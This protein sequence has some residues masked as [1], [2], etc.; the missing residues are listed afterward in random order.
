MKK[1]I[2][3]LGA[4]QFDL[5]AILANMGYSI[6][7]GS[8]HADRENI[9]YALEIDAA[10]LSAP[11]AVIAEALDAVSVGLHGLTGNDAREL[12]AERRIMLE[13]YATRFHEAAEMVAVNLISKHHPEHDQNL[14]VLFSKGKGEE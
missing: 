4:D 8:Y 9:V 10:S 12:L 6:V 5:I 14:Y 2:V 13:M 7:S 3:I 1:H 11:A